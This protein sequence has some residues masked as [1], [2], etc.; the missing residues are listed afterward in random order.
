MVVGICGTLSAVFVTS[1]DPGSLWDLILLLVGFVAAGSVLVAGLPRV[2]AGQRT[3]GLPDLIS[4]PP[5]P[6]YLKEIVDADGDTR[7]V[8]TFDG[9]IH[10]IGDGPLDVVGNPQV[11]GGMV[12]AL[13]Y[14]HRLFLLRCRCFLFTGCTI[15]YRSLQCST[16]CLGQLVGTFISCGKIKR[17]PK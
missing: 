4:D 8:V 14:A 10:N 5:R 13:G 16:P 1:L 15:F 9:Y 12:Q 2:D 17:L 3:N 11:E 6:G 7:L